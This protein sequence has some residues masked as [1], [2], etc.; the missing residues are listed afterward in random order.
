MS[1]ITRDLCS[2]YMTVNLDYDFNLKVVPNGK[3]IPFD[4]VSIKLLEA[5][6]I[7]GSSQIEVH[8]KKWQ[9]VIREILENMFTKL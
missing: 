6:H 4:N 1:E 8:D 2:S 3:L 5:K 7:L 9:V